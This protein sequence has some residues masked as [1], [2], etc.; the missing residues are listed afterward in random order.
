MDILFEQGLFTEDKGKNFGFGIIFSIMSSIGNHKWLYIAT[1]LM[2]GLYYI[3]A[4][5]K[6]AKNANGSVYYFFF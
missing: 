1:Y 2:E 4:N 3:E 6:P 5:Y